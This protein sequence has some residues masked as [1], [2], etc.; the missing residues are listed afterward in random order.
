MHFEVCSTK[1]SGVCSVVCFFSLLRFVVEEDCWLAA[2]TVP[3]R[4]Y[5]GW[6][7]WNGDTTSK[8]KLFFLTS[9]GHGRS[10][11]ICRICDLQMLKDI[12]RHST[13]DVSCFRPYAE[14]KNC[15]GEQ[16]V[17][18]KW[19][20][21]RSWFTPSGAKVSSFIIQKFFR[22]FSLSFKVSVAVVRMS[23]SRSRIMIFPWLLRSWN[24]GTTETFAGH[25]LRH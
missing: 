16:K 13:T 7:R 9:Y 17:C 15:G 20:Q 18:M 23:L 10:Q 24:I 1:M 22:C 19:I 12:W 4:Y 25:Q 6:A 21:F 14:T 5:I 11:W 2:T 8:N 3:S